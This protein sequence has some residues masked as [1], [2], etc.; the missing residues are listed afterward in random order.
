ML[1]IIS[2][3]IQNGLTVLM[4]A[5]DPDHKYIVESLLA[6]NANPNIIDKVTCHQLFF[7]MIMFTVYCI[8]LAT[9]TRCPQIGLA[10]WLIV[11]LLI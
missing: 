2:C 11:S 1:S 8:E 7:D 4:K 6:G 3:V 9:Y 10:M 5:T